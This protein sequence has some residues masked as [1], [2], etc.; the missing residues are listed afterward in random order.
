MASKNLINLMRQGMSVLTNTNRM[1]R[2][3]KN[4]E[5]IKAS[6]TGKCTF[7]FKVEEEH[8][9]G[10]GTLHGGYTAYILDYSTTGAL[11]AM[12]GNRSGVSIDMSLSYMSAAKLG[13][14]V[15]IETECKKKGRNLAFMEAEFKKGDKLLVTGKHTKFIG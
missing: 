13:D 12:E 8:L 7:Q 10:M 6:E 14:I 15:T 4:L 11:M 5:V 3:A 2:L 1:D 9:N